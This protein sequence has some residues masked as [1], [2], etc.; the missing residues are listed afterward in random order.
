MPCPICQKPQIYADDEERKRLMPFCSSRCKLIDLGEW[1]SERYRVP[2]STPADDAI[3]Q[4]R[5]RSDL[6]D[7]T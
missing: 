4:Q 3:E 6:E 1:M 5:D 7:E 2:S